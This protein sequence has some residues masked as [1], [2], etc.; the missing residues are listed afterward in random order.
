MML[1]RPLLVR[2]RRSVAAAITLV[3]ALAGCG[4]PADDTGPR[5]GA[6]NLSGE[7]VV[8]SVTAGGKPHA[9]AP[10]S[11]IRLTFRDG[12][13]GARAGCNHLS[14]SYEI[15]GDELR[16]GPMGGTEMGCPEALMEQDRW[17]AGLFEGAVTV[18][19][20]P[21]TLTSGD[22]VLTLAPREEAAPDR[23][24]VGT[25]WVLDG[26]VEGQSVGS[27]PAGPEVVLTVG[28][29]DAQISGLCNGWG[30]EVAVAGDAVTWT[31]GMRT[32]MACADD[33]RNELD[34]AVASL[35]TGRT[36]YEIEERT[37]RVTRGDRGL[38][39]RA[40]E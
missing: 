23:P 20:D 17:L 40:A 37:L 39:F 7:Y 11:E 35:L 10:G 19:R 3:A 36:A 18:G 33:A 15:E 1:I 26:L 38:V 32:L 25:R 13:L 14:A 34:S 28:E 5:S 4:Q 30:A 24:L 22:V 21:L 9:L 12:Q 8:T 6:G 27:V 31:P 2:V 16:A 29:R